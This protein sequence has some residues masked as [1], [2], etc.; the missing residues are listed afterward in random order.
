M[1]KT[2]QLTNLLSHVNG[3]TFI[4]LDTS[5]TPVLEGGKANPHK[6]RVQKIATG[7]NVMV[8]TNSR[9]NGYENMINKRLVESGMDP[10][11]TVGPLPWGERIP[12]TPLIQHNG[13]MYVQVIFLRPA[14]VHYEL[15]G[16][17]IDRNA[18]IGLKDSETSGEQ[19]GLPKAEKVHL[20]TIKF[21]SITGITI[22]KKHYTF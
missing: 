5:T 9:S 13:G 22:D 6:G 8:F 18:V 21:E 11:F 2:T 16:R 14:K 15:D 3:A 4:S 10:E 17:E 7:A 1:D 19:G 12:G 20:R